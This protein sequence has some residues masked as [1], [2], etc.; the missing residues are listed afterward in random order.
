MTTSTNINNLNILTFIKDIYLSLKHI[1]NCFNSYK[2][3][4]DSRLI[5]LEDNQKT[6]L[7][8]LTNIEQLLDKINLNTQN[9]VALDK[10]I[11]NELMQKM[12]IMNKTSTYEKINLKP[13][14]LTF[15]N[16]LENGYSLLDI[17]ETVNETFNKSINETLPKQNLSSTMTFVSPRDASRNISMCE[18]S[19]DFSNLDFADLD[20]N[21]LDNIPLQNNQQNKKEIDTLDNLLF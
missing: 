10:N 11:E 18:N 20:I 5:K 7:D 2:D 9:Q 4:I 12:N 21:E 6:I 15:A 3:N 1:D 13:E 14:E 16:I 17:N 19:L 8:R